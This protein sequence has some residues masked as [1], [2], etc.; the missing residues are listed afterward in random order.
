MEDR[1]T[2][3]SKLYFLVFGLFLA[4]PVIVALFIGFFYGFFKVFASHPVDVF[5]ELVVVALPPALFA[6]V[7]Y[8]FISRTKKHPSCPV[9][10]ISQLLFV[11]A[12]CVCM[13]VLVADL[14]YYFKLTAGT[15]D[16]GYFSSYSIAFLAG[17]IALLFI[18]A[19]IQA[20]TAGKE[21]DWM[22]KRKKRLAGK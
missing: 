17:N 15:Y 12:F 18:I 6:A 21:D 2:K 9:K 4:V 7:Y 11:L 10:I 13:V 20:F 16:I 14:W 22:E 5:Y 8:I 1:F 3:Y 19:L